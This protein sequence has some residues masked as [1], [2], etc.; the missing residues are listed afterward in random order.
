MTT[1]VL[2]KKR[3]N[4]HQSIETKYRAI[5]SVGDGR[6]KSEIAKE[7]GIPAN[8]LS[9]WLKN[10]EKI[11]DCYENSQFAPAAKKMRKANFS[12]VEEALD[13]WFREARAK[14]IPVK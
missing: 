1:P 12:E 4:N 10:K 6:K 13:L 2:S 7:L 9:T 14:N 3:K 8:T 11:I 5:M